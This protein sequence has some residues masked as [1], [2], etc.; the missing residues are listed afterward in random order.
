MNKAILLAVLSTVFVAGCVGGDLSSLMQ[1]ST[2]TVVGGNGLV[3]TVPR[4]ILFIM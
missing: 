2:T 4:E 1:P 3:I